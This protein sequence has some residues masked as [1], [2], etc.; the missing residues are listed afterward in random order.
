VALGAVLGT[1]ERSRLRVLRM[2]GLMAVGGDAF[3][4]KYNE[5]NKTMNHGHRLARWFAAE[6][7][8]TQCQAITRCD[9]STAAGV[10]QYIERD[11]VR[12]CRAL[13]Q[14]VAAEVDRL[15]EPPRPARSNGPP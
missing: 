11:T 8:S 7:G 14:H 9:F 5:F 13:A 15:I 6:F 1:L 10:T 12:R 4:D 3:A 2:I